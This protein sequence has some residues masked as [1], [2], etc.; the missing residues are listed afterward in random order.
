MPTPQTN[1]AVTALPADW[2]RSSEKLWLPVWKDWSGDAIANTAG[3]LPVMPYYEPVAIAVYHIIKFKTYTDGE[4]ANEIDALNSDAWR[5][6][7]PYQAWISEIHSEGT[8]TVGNADGERVHYVIRCT[9]KD[10]GWKFL[11]PDAGYVYKDGTDFKSFTSLEGSGYIG[12]LD[13]STGAEGTSLMINVAETKDAI[14][15]GSINGLT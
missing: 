14:A 4:F 6:F 5:G 3:L 11:H 1:P 12:M 2:R 15:F 10:D 13:G 9:N 8:E 7:Q